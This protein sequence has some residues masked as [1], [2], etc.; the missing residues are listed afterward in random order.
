MPVH[1]QVLIPLCTCN[2]SSSLPYT[3]MPVNVQF[4]NN[5]QSLLV[6]AF[7]PAW[8]HFFLKHD[9]NFLRQLGKQEKGVSCV[10]HKSDFMRCT[11][12]YDYVV[13]DCIQY[14]MGDACRKLWS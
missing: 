5:K 14:A 11:E 12:S 4:I 6:L 9:R 10:L 2:E 13:M 1:T 8:I 7:F 3:H